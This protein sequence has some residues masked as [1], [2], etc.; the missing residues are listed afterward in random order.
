MPPSTERERASLV[1]RE[2]A[3]LLEISPWDAVAPIRARDLDSGRD[4]SFERV[5][6]PTFRSLLGHRRIVSLI[7]IGC[8]VGRLTKRIS[9]LTRASITAIDPSPVSIQ[10]AQQ[11][12]GN[13]PKF[14]LHNMTIQQYTRLGY[15]GHDTA[16]ASMVMQDLVDLSDFLEACHKSLRPGG[17][18]IAAITHPSFW[19]SYWNYA[20][21]PWYRYD[22]EL[23]I[24]SEFRTS[25]S[26]SGVDTLHVHR[27][28]ESYFD[29]FHE[30]GFA[31]ARIREPLMPEAD[32][33]RNGVRWNSPHF[34]FFD[35]KRQRT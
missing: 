25:L 19:P 10:I 27:P 21:E 17:R 31:V 11:H 18:L 3:R 26:K 24:R 2:E 15:G 6:V 33:I 12:L 30:S 9:E 5:I 14:V 20:S 7:D 29:R 1:E 13:S 28:M 34:L 32:Q 4:P 16:I 22:R 35:A 23:Y 8:G